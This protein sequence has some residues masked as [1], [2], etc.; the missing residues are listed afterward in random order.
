[1]KKLITL[2]LAVLSLAAVA[3]FGAS[4]AKALNPTQTDV[5][6]IV[7]TVYWDLDQFWGAPTQKPGVG[8]Y[9][10]VADGRLVNY[11]TECGSTANNI[12]YQGFYC[13]GGHIYL[14]YNQQRGHVANI[15]DGAVA[16][17]LAHEY[18]HSAEWLRSLNWPAPYHELLADCFAGLYFRWGV[19]SSGKLAYNDYLEARTMLSRMG[20]DAAHGGPAQRLRAFD[21]GFNRVGWTSCTAGWQYW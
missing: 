19:Y 9:D 21:Y 13:A 20:T 17:W 10:Y 8:Y 5:V 4:E 7:N 12:G 14:D 15:G 3:A 2:A 1:V 16:L 11:Q 18:G 6:T